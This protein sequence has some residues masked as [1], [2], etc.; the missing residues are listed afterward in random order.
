[1]G[2]YFTGRGGQP[3][4]NHRVKHR[5]G[6][7]RPARRER[8]GKA[9]YRAGRLAKVLFFQRGKKTIWAG[10][11]TVNKKSR[12]IPPSKRG[13]RDSS[14]DQWWGGGVKKD[15]ANQDSTTSSRERA[16]RWGVGKSDNGEKES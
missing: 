13:A 10:G 14:A 9:R 3:A 12:L 4:A 15:Q 8:E 11:A 1:V 16:G 5:H 7:T 2:F 6:G